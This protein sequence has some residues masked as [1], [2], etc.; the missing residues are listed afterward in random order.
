MSTLT[1]T[2]RWGVTSQSTSGGMPSGLTAPLYYEVDR[3]LRGTASNRDASHP[4]PRLDSALEGYLQRQVEQGHT[5]RATVAQA[6]VVYL[7]L[8]QIAGPRLS[9]PNTGVGPDGEIL[10]SWNTAVHHFEAEIFPAGTVELFALRHDTDETWEHEASVDAALPDALG[11]YLIP[12]TR[13]G[14]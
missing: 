8:L 4:V 1:A 3:R 5:T 12:F 9:I 13:D 14:R 7:A 10:F 2:L 6:R 11:T